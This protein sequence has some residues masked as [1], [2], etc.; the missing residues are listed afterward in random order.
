MSEVISPKFQI[1]RAADAPSLMKS[2][3]MTV[4]PFD[5]VQRAGM[6]KLVKAGYMEGDEEKVLFN[7]PGFSLLHVWFKKDYPLLRHTH[8]SDCLYYVIAGSLTL[9]TE[10][11]SARDGFFVPAGTPYTY[12]PGADGVELLE[13]RHATHFNLINLTK[14]EAFYNRAAET[15]AANLEN[16]RQAK[17][18]PLNVS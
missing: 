1:F 4:Q 10:T 8:D 6:D 12:R 18:P 3:L 15:V 14:G 5:D 16:W 11:L 7:V 2:G 13:F 9:G 17:K